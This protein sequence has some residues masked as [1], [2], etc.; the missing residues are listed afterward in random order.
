MSFRLTLR[1]TQ[2]QQQRRRKR[3]KKPEAEVKDV[4]G[5]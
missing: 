4:F 3:K 2:P 1:V 5:L